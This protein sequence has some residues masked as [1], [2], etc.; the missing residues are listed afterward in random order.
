VEID[1]DSGEAA[2]TNGVLEATF[3]LK[4]SAKTDSKDIEVK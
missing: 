1:K 3:K 2:Y 4:E